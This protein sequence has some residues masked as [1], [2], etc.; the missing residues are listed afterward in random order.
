M[1]LLYADLCALFTWMRTSIVLVPLNISMKFI[2]ISAQK[3]ISNPT[4]LGYETGF[5]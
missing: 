2:V 1:Y 5:K 4:K 3:I